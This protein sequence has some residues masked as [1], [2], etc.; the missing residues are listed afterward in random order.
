VAEELDGS[1]PKFVVRDTNG[2]K[3]KVKLGLEARP[4]TVCTRLVWAAGYFADEDYFVRELKVTGLPLR[5]HRGR[6]FVGPD[7][8]VHNARLKRENSGEKK[9][10]KWQ[11]RRDAF[12]GT[13]EL[14][15][16]RVLMAVVNNWDLKDVNN[17]IYQAG[18]ERIYMISD[19]GASFG[20]AGRTWPR[21][22]AKDNLASYSQSQFIHRVTPETVDFA[23]P[24]RPQWVFWVDPPATLRRVHLEWIGKNVPR[25]DA[26]FIGKLLARISPQQLRDA[27]R[28]GGYSPEETEEFARLVQ[29][30]IS[31]LTDL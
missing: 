31:A 17:A 4:E 9:I 30:R 28:A 14:N 7:G 3:W 27:F 1:S 10:G 19:L 16:L 26:K 2:Q 12:A 15:G 22:R 8:L 29:Q 11:W 23:V 6:Q 24:A 5:L 21:P 18:A 13:R 20:S 25:R